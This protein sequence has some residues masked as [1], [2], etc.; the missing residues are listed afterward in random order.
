MLAEAVAQGMGGGGE[1]GEGVGEDPLQVLLNEGLVG[2]FVRG[3]RGTWRAFL[4]VVEGVAGSDA[5]RCARLVRDSKV[6]EV[7]AE[8]LG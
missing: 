1:E 2:G 5:G 3:G 8:V 7:L 6:K 4:R